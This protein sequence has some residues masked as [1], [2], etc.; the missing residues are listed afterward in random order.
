MKVRVL[1]V[2]DEPI[3]ADDIALTLGDLGFEV[4]DM[5]NSADLAMEAIKR[6][7]PDLLLL[8]IKIKG[9]KDGIRLAHE[10]NEQFNIPFVFLSSLYDEQT[11]QRAKSTRPAGYVVKPFKEQDLKVTLE[12]ALNKKHHRVSKPNETP[13]NFFV[14]K[15]GAMVPLNFE[16]VT[17]VEADDNY[18]IFHEAGS[19]HVVSHTL[20]DIEQKLTSAG[21]CR[22]HKSFL[23]NI[24]HIDRI[25]HSVLFIGET[26][27]P[28]GKAY[29]KS[30]F[31]RLTVF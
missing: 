28:I 15:A 18:C 5:V 27:L 22:V 30:F 14:R 29:R 2:E 20:K 19:K 17:Y 23:V 9:E 31:D 24:S 25:E 11:L 26:M 10:I 13:L 16:E 4:A 21:F 1:I 3:I 12:L 8:D 6:T 7:E